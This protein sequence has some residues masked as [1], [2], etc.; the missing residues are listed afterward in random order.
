MKQQI[1][2]TID[3]YLEDARSVWLQQQADGDQSQ[4][5][6]CECL[7]ETRAGMLDGALG[8][9]VQCS[10]TSC[11]PEGG[12]CIIRIVLG[13]IVPLRW[14]QACSLSEVSCEDCVGGHENFSQRFDRVSRSNLLQI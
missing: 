4:D 11:A 2:E 13:A 5:D 3:E 10:Y 9:S 1:H 8:P 14:V 7:C 6:A 12:G